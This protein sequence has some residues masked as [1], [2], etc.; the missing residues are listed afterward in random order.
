VINTILNKRW[1]QHIERLH[2]SLTWGRAVATERV[3]ALTQGFT[4]TLGSDADR[5][6]L[7]VLSNSARREGLV[8]AFSDVFL[9]LAVV[10][11]AVLFLVP[12]ARRPKP[13]PAGAGGGH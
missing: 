8:M 12:L 3:T 7:A 13:A 4:A 11:A 6:A 9:I 10:F 1:D 5:A 2:E